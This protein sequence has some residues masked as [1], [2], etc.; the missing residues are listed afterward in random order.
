M[1]AIHV[2]PQNQDDFTAAVHGIQQR[3][4]CTPLLVYVNCV[5]QAACCSGVG[6]FRTDVPS[7]IVVLFAACQDIT[8]APYDTISL[9][10]YNHTRQLSNAKQIVC[11]R[12]GVQY[13]KRSNDAHTKRSSG[14]LTSVG[15]RQS[16][17]GTIRKTRHPEIAHSVSE[18]RSDS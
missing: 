5:V 4:C 14:R 13:A 17:N 7:K 15:G 11:L 6:K 1:E 9:L 8:S 12:E 2:S 10:K 3:D 18:I 16:M